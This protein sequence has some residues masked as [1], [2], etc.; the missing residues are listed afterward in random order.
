MLGK[1]RAL[2]TWE[3]VASSSPG[4]TSTSLTFSVVVMAIAIMTKM[5]RVGGRRKKK[6]KWMMGKAG[7][8]SDNLCVRELCGSC[9]LSTRKE[10]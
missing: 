5:R 6:V 8:F 7:F 1:D 2:Q 10:F 3:D 4:L 9:D